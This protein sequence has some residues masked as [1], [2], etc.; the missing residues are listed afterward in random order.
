MK[1]H[2][3]LLALTLG[4]CSF[5]Q[6]QMQKP[7][8]Q[9]RL[10]A[11]LL[12]SDGQPNTGLGAS[13]AVDG[14]IVAVAAGENPGSVYLFSRL[15]KGTVTQIAT[16]N[17]SDGA[18][19]FA[20][21]VG[22]NGG[23]VVAGAPRETIGHNAD[24]GAVYVFLEPEGGWTGNVMETAKL[25]ASDGGA[26]NELG[27]SVSTTNG[28]IV[29][30]AYRGGGQ[31][32]GEA[33]VYV[34][35]K[36]GWANR[37]ETAQLKASNGQTGDG[38]GGSVSVYGPRV[39]VGADGFND[40]EGI[41]YVFQEPV[42]G[43]KTMTETAQLTH[44][45]SGEFLG[46]SVAVLGKTVVAGAPTTSSGGAVYIY[47]QPPNGWVS[48]DTPNAT[49][50]EAGSLCLGDTVAIGSTMVAV[51]DAC[52][53]YGHPVRFIGDSVVYLMPKDGWKD[54]SDGIIIRPK[55][56]DQNSVVAVGKNRV[57]V[58]SPLTDVGN[59]HAQG[60]AFI[61]TVPAQ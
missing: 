32:Q 46:I 47:V 48:T 23:L 2:A 38:F 41:V 39:V 49:L 17:A 60:A 54:S 14:N 52:I 44:P 50:T 21:A 40:D 34:E 16:L 18:G 3:W 12:A 33:Y 24:Q 4:N 6:A 25:T 10:N 59:S 56:G 45:G 1:Y 15:S 55:G 13:V 29:A 61:F 30:G 11:E 27:L 36:G 20:V 42:G 58:G 22:E 53:R 28:V 35:P 9:K 51:G 26:N 43:W 19:L 57:I 31:G 7:M 8:A 37:T 5:A